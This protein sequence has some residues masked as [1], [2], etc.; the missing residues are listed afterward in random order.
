VS[1]LQSAASA[2]SC[3]SD[4]VRCADP[5]NLP[6]Q[7]RCPS[8]PASSTGPVSLCC[9]AVTRRL[10]RRGARGVLSERGQMGVCKYLV[11]NQGAGDT[12]KR[13]VHEGQEPDLHA[14]LESR[15]GARRSH[16]IHCRHRHTNPLLRPVRGLADQATACRAS[17]T[18]LS[19]ADGHSPRASVH[20]TPPNSPERNPARPQE[21]K[22]GTL[23]IMA[24]AQSPSAHPPPHNRFGEGCSNLSLACTGID[25]DSQLSEPNKRIFELARSG[26]AAQHLIRPTAT[27]LISW[28]G[29][30]PC[31]IV[32]DSGLRPEEPPGSPFQALISHPAPSNAPRV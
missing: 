6:P 16:Q 17:A 29:Q 1:P 28:R 14:D 8:R 15:I 2:R 30:V 32:H 4:E 3:A 21:L 24:S 26:Y 27:L 23:G 10:P 13:V 18:P 31:Q 9:A 25:I 22:A 12:E 19:H 11:T 5:E 7:K 20:W